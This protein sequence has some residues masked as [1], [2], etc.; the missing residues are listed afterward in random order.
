MLRTRHP[1][2]WTSI[3]FGGLFLA[4]VADAAPATIRAVELTSRNVGI[5]SVDEYFLE[6]R[7]KSLLGAE[8]IELILPDGVFTAKVERIDERKNGYTWYGKL[9]DAWDVMLTNHDGA[10]AGLIYTPWV[11]YE[12]FSGPEGSPRLAM[13]DHEKYP[14]CAQTE[15]PAD[16]AKDEAFDVAA[17]TAAAQAAAAS[18]DPIVMDVLVVYTPQARSGAGGTAQIQSTI[19]AAIDITN[20]AYAN[21]NVD[22]VLNLVHMQEVTYNDSG[23]SSTDLSFVRNDATVAA[24]RNTH[25]ADLVGLIVNANDA[26]GRGYVQ[27][28]PGPSFAPF[29]VQV[30]TRSCAVGNLSFAHEFGHNQGCEHDPANGTSPSSASYP[31]SFGHFHSGAYRT[32]MSYSTQCTGG[33][34]RAPY[35]SNPSV[36]HQGLPTGIANQRDNHRTINLTASIVADF[37]P[38]AS[39]S[40]AFGTATRSQ[41]DAATFYSQNISGAP[42][43]PVV[44][45]GPPSFNGAQASVVR[46]RNVTN[47]SFQY[48]VD[49]WDYL[50]GGHT[51]ESIGW[52][53]LGRGNQNIGSL[54]AQAGA[55]SVDHDWT[56]VNLSQS[57]SSAPVVLA[58]IATRNGS[59][60]A[61]TRIR[62]V[63]TS[64]F[65][66][67]VQEEEGNDGTHAVETVHFLAIQ[68]GATTANGNRVV[69]GRTGNSVTDAFATINFSTVGS[70]SFF[71]NMQTF[72]GGDPA[73]LRYRNLSSTSV[74]VKVEEEASAD[75]EVGHTTEVVGYVVIGNP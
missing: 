45:M 20:T 62:N 21:S 10:V 5:A 4:S 12:V 26:C 67:R 41:A 29:A 69:V 54:P 28:S 8:A 27:R 72:D 9:H 13:I 17:A 35:F 71:A 50:D 56:T 15:V 58:Q 40:F 64:S 1:I 34:S 32:V 68:P 3:I 42:S 61:T 19:Q 44:L 49:E 25:G 47:Q 30:T 2:S 52:L 59:Q 43:N 51:T 38:S 57:F 48:Q 14:G 70:P 63:T 24:L 74:Q 46:V 18:G 31:F 6:V 39:A 37:R 73:A 23:S 75:A 53:A 65:Q 16:A 11:T 55:V 22:A 7:A 33:C 36:S 66:V 60:A